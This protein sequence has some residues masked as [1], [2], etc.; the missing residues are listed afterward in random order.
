MRLRNIPGSRETI[1]ESEFTVHDEESYKGK[2]KEYFGNDKPIHIEIGM[3]K[4]TFIIEMAKRYPEVNFV[5]IEKYSSV[6]VRALEKMEGME[7]RPSNLVFIRMDADYIE[8]VF[9]KKEVDMIYLNFSDPWPKARNAK[10]R[11]TSDRFLGRYINILNDGGGIIFK[12]DNKDLFEFSVETAQECGWN[13]TKI[14]RDLHKS[15]YAEGN[16]MT[17][18]EKK[19]SQLGNKINMMEYYPPEKNL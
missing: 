17:E 9:D 4:G 13:I 18:Y 14:T 10:R 7:E 5:G 2:W 15:E 8:N 6:L 12:T 16:I 11:L 19:F 1:A 3:G